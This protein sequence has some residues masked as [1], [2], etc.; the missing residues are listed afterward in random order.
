VHNGIYLCVDLLAHL[1][2]EFSNWKRAHFISVL[3]FFFLNKL[4]GSIFLLR[5]P[6]GE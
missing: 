1:L 2:I 5:L 6:G 3:C 4:S